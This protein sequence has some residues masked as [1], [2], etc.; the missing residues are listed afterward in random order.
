MTVFS[1]TRGGFADRI[2]DSVLKWS[3]AAITVALTVTLSIPLSHAMIPVEGD[4]G[5]TVAVDYGG[6]VVIDAPASDLPVLRAGF[7]S[8]MHSFVNPGDPAVRQL[9]SALSTGRGGMA[10]LESVT[11]WIEWNIE[12][13]SDPKGIV[14]LDRWQMVGETLRIEAGDCEDM[15]ILG[16]S[17]MS[18]L[19]YRTVLIFEAGHVL[20]GAE[21][22]HAVHDCTVR[23][24]GREYVTADPTAGCVG[25]YCE[26]FLV[27]DS[28]WNGQAI[29][30]L[31]F[32]GAMEAV[33]L[34]L[35][36]QLFRRGA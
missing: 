8:S 34:V 26:P 15:A 24:N 36:A 3:F 2:P 10:D 19:G 7:A 5:H 1:D 12:Y 28:K 17:V 6:G 13:A 32:L 14:T 23:C 16:A 27:T 9:A 35:L 30:V 29:L 20:F 4:Y 21:V 22:E 18:A 33:M 25:V 31:A 11:A